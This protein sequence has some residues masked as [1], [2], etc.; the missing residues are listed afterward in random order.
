[1][2]AC[3]LPQQVLSAPVRDRAEAGGVLSRPSV[4]VGPVER[5]PAVAGDDREG[6]P[7]VVGDD[8]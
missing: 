7:A 8:R 6:R 5:R 2:V 4:A 1:M 3:S